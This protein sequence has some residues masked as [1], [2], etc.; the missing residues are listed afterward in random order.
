[1]GTF[2]RTKIMNTISTILSFFLVSLVSGE[3]P[4]GWTN[5]G[6]DNCYLVSP[7]PMTW[8]AA[9]EVMWLST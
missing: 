4:I 2:I 6:G 8:G 7:S 1:M 9:Q 5:Y 3:C